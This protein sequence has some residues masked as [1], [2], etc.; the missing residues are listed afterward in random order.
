MDNAFFR[1]SATSSSCFDGLEI[2]EGWLCTNITPEQRLSIAYLQM[3]LMSTTDP[4]IPPYEIFAYPI[5]FI[6]R[7]TNMI[8]TL[9]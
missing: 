9:S 2:P 1:L 3:I 7:L 8:N 6:L 4:E 5:V